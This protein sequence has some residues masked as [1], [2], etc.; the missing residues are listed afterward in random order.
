[1]RTVTSPCVR[2]RACRPP[3]RRPR[4]RPGGRGSGAPR[5]R[6]SEGG[7]REALR[8]RI[9]AHE[10]VR[11]EVAQPD[12]V[13]LVD[14]DRVRLGFAPGARHSASAVRG[15]YI[16]DLARVPLAD[17]DAAR[18]SDHTRRAPCPAVGGSSDGRLA[19][20]R[21]DPAEVAPGERRVVDV[22]RRRRVIPYGP[23]PRGA[24]TPASARCRVEPAVDAGLAGEPEDAVAGR[25][26]RC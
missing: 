15:S 6:R 19:G 13:A 1:M 21:V 25:R 10:R 22:A 26:S 2:G 11:A 3:T 18:E 7:R 9:E 23:R 24:R 17:P 4:P 8:H 20:S 12:D 16:A 5:R 14:V